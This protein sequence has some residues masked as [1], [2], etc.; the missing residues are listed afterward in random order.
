MTTLGARAKITVIDDDDLVLEHLMDGLR[1]LNY[2][3][4][5]LKDQYGNELERMVREI[6]AQNPDFVICDHRLQPFGL[7]A[8]HGLGVVRQLLD[9]KRPAML[10]TMY[11][12]TDRMR[13]TLR[14]S[15]HLL[16]VIAG[17]DDFE[18]EN[19]ARYAEIVVRE[20]KNDPVEERRAHRTLL[21]VEWAEPDTGNET[22]DVV[23]NGWS[24]DHAVTVPAACIDPSIIGKIRTGD[25]LLGSINI[26]AEREDDLFFTRIDEIVDVGKVEG[27]S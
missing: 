1:D 8:F 11:Q 27:L 9:F 13:M 26:G 16:P 2:E 20:L 4:M 6:E 15:R 17:R 22:I 3:P 7:A 18:A 19:V 5:T 21:K 10:L 12:Q 23:V 24:P 14:S 25:F